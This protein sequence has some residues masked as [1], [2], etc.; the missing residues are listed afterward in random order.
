MLRPHAKL[1]PYPIA[2]LVLLAL[3]AGPQ[4]RAAS[5]YEVIRQE[6]TCP[7]DGEPRSLRQTVIVLDEAVVAAQPEANQRWTRIVVDAAEARESAL[8]NLGTRERLTLFVARRDGSELV[9]LFTGCSPNLPAT[10]TEKAKAADSMMDRFLGNDSGAKRKLA[11]D[12]FGGGIARALA[13][14]QKRAGDIAAQPAP[15]GGLLR[16]L[17][18]AGRLADPDLG[19]PRIILVSPFQIPEKGGVTDVPAARERGFQLAE[20]SGIDLGRAEIYLAGAAL[21]DTAALEF[22]RAFLLGSKG[23]LAGV[24]SDGLPRLLP[25][26]TTRRIYAGFVD[27]VGQ[28]IP[29]QMRIAAAANGDLVNAWIEST[30]SRTTATPL[31]GKMLCRGETCE[32]HGDGRFAQAWFPDP[33]GEPKDRGKLPFGGA[34]NVELTLRKDGASGRISDPKVIFSG[35]NGQRREELRFDIQ[36]VEG[37]PF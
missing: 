32:V 6:Q 16:A 19:L 34:R 28:R 23:L 20:K 4:A 27:Y 8:G 21:G 33:Q 22:A 13:Q 30:V 36:R 12:A 25:E 5:G 35:E 1:G 29:L 15:A 14:V 17:Q 37:A 11:Q 26:P 3:A 2:G 7:G 9:L 18:N 31:S 10:E 24:R